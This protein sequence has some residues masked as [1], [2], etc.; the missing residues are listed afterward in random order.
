MSADTEIRPSAPVVRTPPPQPRTGRP[1]VASRSAGF[2]V[3]LVLAAMTIFPFTWMV[4]TSLRPSNTVFGGSFL[5]EEYSLDAYGEAW[6]SIGFGS[7]FLNSVVITVVTVAGTLFLATLSG[8]AFAMLRFP[9]RNT[10]YFLLLS[11]LMMPASALIIPLYLQLRNLGLLDSRYG[12]VLLYIGSSTPF[13]MFLMRAF[14]ETLPKE[15]IEAARA[16]GAGEFTVF[17]RV[18]LPLA[19]PGIA[20]VVIFQSLSTWNEF[21]YANTVIQS[22]EKLPL[23]PILFTLTGQYATNWP[24]LTAALTM[25]VIPVIVVYVRMQRQFVAGMTLGAVKN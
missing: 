9:L 25:A 20:T 1:G 10:I 2:V 23:Q 8:Y 13:A 5:P 22:P 19:R 21:L 6:N 4:L 7:H 12:L 18:M 15:L 16:D 14:F 17:W 24:V 3:L 11:T